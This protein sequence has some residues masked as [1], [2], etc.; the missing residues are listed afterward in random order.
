MKNIYIPFDLHIHTL[1]TFSKGKLAKNFKL[2]LK[3]ND[4]FTDQPN[5]IDLFQKQYCFVTKDKVL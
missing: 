4:N 2:R 3:T 1:S 5:C